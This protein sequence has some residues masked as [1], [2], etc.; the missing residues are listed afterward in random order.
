MGAI[1][2]SGRGQEG[3]LGMGWEWESDELKI[4]NPEPNNELPIKWGFGGPGH[5]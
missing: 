5:T 1:Y 3:I 2:I 4:L